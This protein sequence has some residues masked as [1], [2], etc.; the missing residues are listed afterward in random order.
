MNYNKRL[1]KTIKLWHSNRRL[2]VTFC[3]HRIIQLSHTKSIKC[4]CVL[5]KCM[6]YNKLINGTELISNNFLLNNP[7]IVSMCFDSTPF[8]T[9]KMVKGLLLLQQLQHLQIAGWILTMI[10]LSARLFKHKKIYQTHRH[11]FKPCYCE[12]KTVKFIL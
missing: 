11:G 4:A 9:H 2:I 5:T 8:F 7:K 12:H 3:G 1:Q 6:Y 10:C